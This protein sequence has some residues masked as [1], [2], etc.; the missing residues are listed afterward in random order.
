M[1]PEQKLKLQRFSYYFDFYLTVL[2]LFHGVIIPW[3]AQ[4]NNCEV[5]KEILSTKSL[6][7][8]FQYQQIY[9]TFWAFNCI[10]FYSKIKCF[11]SLIQSLIHGPYRLEFHTSFKWTKFK[12]KQHYSVD[13]KSNLIQSMYL[14]YK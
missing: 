11:E 1:L 9:N 5:W 8:Q 7:R 6:F 3:F 14:S 10:T 13:Y 4:Y 12:P 2:M